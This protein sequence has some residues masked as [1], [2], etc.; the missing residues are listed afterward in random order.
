MSFR[1]ADLLRLINQHGKNLTFTT[2]GSMTYNPV[3]GGTTGTDTT[4]TVR[5][6]FYNY[7]AS[8]ITGSSIVIGDRRL[9]ISTVDTS[10]ATLTA[11][12]KG[13]TFAG[14]GDTM[15]VV[16]VERIMSG[17]NPVC[18]ICQTRE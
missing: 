1:S 14:E 16:S 4:K 11:P 10:G 8:D 18:Y 15:V 3:T 13:D 7:S 12:K 17:D 9:V 6:Y 2:K 5:G